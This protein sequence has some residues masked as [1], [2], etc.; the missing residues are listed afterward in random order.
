MTLA[1]TGFEEISLALLPR[2]TLSLTVIR[3]A[4]FFFFIKLLI[5]K[6]F[7]FIS[8]IYIEGLRHISGRLCTE[9]GLCL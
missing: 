7:I 3:R 8:N 1:I 2:T 4:F 5:F 9:G 6:I